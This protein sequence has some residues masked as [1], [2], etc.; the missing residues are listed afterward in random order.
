M[1]RGLRP[2]SVND[3]TR[4]VISRVGGL[5]AASSDIGLS[6]STLSRSYSDDDDRPGGLGVK[7]LHQLARIVPAA[8]VPV[9]EHFARLAGGVF[10]PMAGERA[11]PVHIHVLTKEFSDVLNQNA[12]AHSDASIDPAGYTK[13]EAVSEAKELEELAQ[14][15][16]ARRDE[17][18]AKARGQ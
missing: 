8:A 11:G 4:S 2:G 18:L 10:L 7:Y 15:A 9:A 17:L 12:A 6:V 5:E 14:V 16:L 1:A 13:V 3:M